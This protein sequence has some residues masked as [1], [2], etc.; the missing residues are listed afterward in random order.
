[1]TQPCRGSPTVCAGCYAAHINAGKRARSGL[2]QRCQHLA[3]FGS[4]CQAL[5]LCTADSEVVLEDAHRVTVVA[6]LVQDRAEARACI[7]NL[8]NTQ[9]R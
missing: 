8:W 6:L 1:M 9:Q 7:A 5:G 4:F 3:L 2:R